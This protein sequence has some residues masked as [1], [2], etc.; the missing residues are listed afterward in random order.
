M[1]KHISL[2]LLITL[3]SVSFSQNPTPPSNIY[4]LELRNWLRSNWYNGFHN[5]LGYSSAR[6]EMYSYIDNESGQVYCVY[7]G[8][9]QGA[10][11]T[12][13]LN[14][15]NCEHTVPQSFFDSAEPMKSDIHHLFP[16][17]QDVNTAR[18]NNPFDDINDSSTNKW[19]IGNASG[20]TQ[21]TSPPN[22]NIDQY[23]ELDTGN[24]FEPREDHKGNV[25][26]AVLY[27]FTMYPT[28]AGNLNSVA[29]LNTLYQWHLDDPVDAQEIIRNNKTQ[30]TQG[31]YNPYISMPDLVAKAWGFFNIGIENNQIIPLKLYP[32]PSS[33][34]LTINT[35]ENFEYK[36]VSIHG[37]TIEKGIVKNA[38]IDISHLENGTYVIILFNADHIQMMKF[39]KK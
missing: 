36:F 14:P 8:Y 12:S 4:D 34:S 27:F 25:A 24:S 15:I 31:N 18:S 39:V 7:S 29:D 23:S 37:Q 26:R 22:T 20:L 13:Y 21:S 16:T 9:H 33:K 38:T 3:S 17:H 6:E 11:F 28:Q 35:N 19:Y 2:L 5:T 1:K 30:E 32:N 10:A